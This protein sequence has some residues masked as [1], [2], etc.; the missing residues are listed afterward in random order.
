MK[1]V[2]IT[3][4]SGKIGQVLQTG[5]QGCSMVYPLDLPWCDAKDMHALEREFPG[6]DVVIH[7]AWNAKI[8]NWRSGTIDPDNTLMTFNVFQ[9]AVNTRVPRVIM[10]SSVHA[11]EFLTWKRQE[12]LTT[13]K[14]P[15][16]TSP[17]GASKI[18]ME[19]L[20][21]YYSKHHNL[22]VICIR[23]GGVNPQN[24]ITQEMLAAEP[25]LPKVWFSHQDCV[26]LVRACIKAQTVPNNFTIV[27]GVS[28]NPERIHD[29]TNPFG[30]TPLSSQG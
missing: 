23:F 22:E 4:S 5:L 11:D 17:Y 25:I 14:T 10:A 8:E 13:D 12:L 27:Y 20:G 16:P 24:E 19:A 18:F 29:L 2:A 3:G 26:A 15:F 30:W 6:K 1:K 9:A 7:L 21:R 28:D